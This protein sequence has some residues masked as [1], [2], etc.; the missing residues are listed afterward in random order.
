MAG[1]ITIMPD[2]NLTEPTGV[3]WNAQEGRLLN[4]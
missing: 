1:T 3:V 4:E 2:A